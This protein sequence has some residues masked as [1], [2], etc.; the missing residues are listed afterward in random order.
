RS[1]TA[2]PFSFGTALAGMQANFNA[3]FPVGADKSRPG[4]KTT[5]V[6]V[7]PANHFGLYD[8]HGNVWE[9]WAD[10]DDGTYYQPSPR[11]DPVGP[12]DGRFRVVRGGSWRN[13]AATCRAAYRNALVPNNRDAYTG[14]RVVF[15]TAGGGR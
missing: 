4:D 5:P 8:M 11:R 10:W 2:T 3:E 14:F 9:W 15:S 6:G 7:F 12:E 1:G 13:H